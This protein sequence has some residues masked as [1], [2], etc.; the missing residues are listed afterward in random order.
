MFCPKC[1]KELPDT[2][3]YCIHCGQPINN[4][5]IERK[6][7]TVL[8][9]T[10]KSLK[11]FK[12]LFAILICLVTIGAFMFL[13]WN[14]FKTFIRTSE[15]QSVS[16]NALQNLPMDN[17]KQTPTEDPIKLGQFTRFDYDSFTV[18]YYRANDSIPT[19]SHDEI[20]QEIDSAFDYYDMEII[21]TDDTGSSLSLTKEKINGKPYGFLS[22]QHND[23]LD[24]D[25]FDIFYY[26][27]PE[28]VH[29]CSILY[30]SSTPIDTYSFT[31][32]DTTYNKYTEKDFEEIEGGGLADDDTIISSGNNSENSSQSSSNTFSLSKDELALRTREQLERYLRDDYF[33]VS[34][35]SNLSVDIKNSVDAGSV[36]YNLVNC[37]KY[38]VSGNVHCH[39]RNSFYQGTFS[40]TLYATSYNTWSE[41][42]AVMSTK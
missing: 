14:N 27:T 42:Y 35:I 25:N 39:A 21:W 10:R 38:V 13:N 34:G 37:E 30:V 7:I 1:S 8:P 17:P 26:D 15:P 5:D 33:N 23:D 9:K 41:T 28:E 19:M 4:N 2:A 6:N 31:I 29:H 16:G 24:G 18:P 22:Y 36:Q 32:D 12:S 11:I 3:M 20:E 40:M